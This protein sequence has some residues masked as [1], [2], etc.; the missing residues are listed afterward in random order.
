M[1]NRYS[2]DTVHIRYARIKSIG[3]APYTE[4]C[5]C[6]RALRKSDVLY[7]VT[8]LATEL[9]KRKKK[10]ADKSARM[11]LLDLTKNRTIVRVRALGL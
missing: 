9:R 4:R 8:R 10:T 3:F 5:M 7:D 11:V 6:A 1:S 2:P